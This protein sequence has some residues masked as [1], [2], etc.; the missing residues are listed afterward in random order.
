MKQASDKI[1]EMQKLCDEMVAENASSKAAVQE[2]KATQVEIDRQVDAYA[3][4]I[5][6]RR[7][8]ER[9]VGLILTFGAALAIGTGILFA[10]LGLDELDKID[11]KVSEFDKNADVIKAR[12]DDEIRTFK[13][14]LDSTI[15][16]KIALFFDR[17]ETKAETYK[18]NVNDLK[19]LIDVLSQAEER[20]EEIKPA[21]EGLGGYD[22]DADLKGDFLSIIEAEQKA[23]LG[24]EGPT[25]AEQVGIVLR[26][27]NHLRNAEENPEF[28]LQFTPDDIFNAAQ[29]ARRLQRIDLENELINAAYDL[30][31]SSPS[32]RALFLQLQARYGPQ[33]ERGLRYAELL[34]LIGGLTL[35]SPHIVMAE[36]WNAAEGL[37]RYTE[38]ISAID[39]RIKSAKENPGIL[40]PSHAFAIKGNAHQ[41]RGLPSELQVA[42]D[43]YVKAIDRLAREGTQT[44][45][46]EATIGNTLQGVEQLIL[47]GIDISPIVDAADLSGIIPLKQKLSS[48]VIASQFQTNIINNDGREEEF[49]QQLLEKMMQTNP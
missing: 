41:R 46:A 49:M 39:E 47:S 17:N 28:A 9:T 36:A 32:V 21:L 11:T 35:D 6:S 24:A 25:R 45:W 16:D 30:D 4:E 5:A 8:Y 3:L 48:L 33:E 38:L 2:L 40:L 44:Q 27:S 7:S 31:S 18:R 26:I 22:R 43:S 15:D 12:L 14:E 37:R 19:R 34:G 20:W 1:L 10:F 42:L 29:I 23:N 13:A